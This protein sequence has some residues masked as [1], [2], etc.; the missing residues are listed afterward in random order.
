[1]VTKISTLTDKTKSIRTAIANF[2]DR[3]KRVEV[4]LMVVED[5]LN[6]V[7]DRD[8]ELLCLR[9]K[10]TGLEYQSHRDNVCFFGFTEHAEGT[11]IRGFLKGLLPSLSGLVFTLPLEIQRVHHLGPARPITP[12]CPH[13]IITCFIRHEQ[14][15]QLLSPARSHGP[16]DQ[17]GHTLCIAEGFSKEITDRRKAFLAFR[18][19]LG[20][21]DIKFRLFKLAQM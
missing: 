12:E 1:M 18:P 14:V 3:A 21:M 20:R 5:R 9:D 16:Y 15:M 11:G 19:R 2:Q 7:S 10:V 4:R 6:M 13:P 8:R 17:E